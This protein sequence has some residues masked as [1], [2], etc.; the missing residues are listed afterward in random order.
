MH[1]SFPTAM[2]PWTLERSDA[3]VHILHIYKDYFPVVGG[4]ENHIRMLAEA[5]AAAGHRVTVL[6]CAP[7][8]RTREEQ[9]HGV[10]VIKAG[11]LGTVASMP[12]SISQP[13]YL[14]RLWPDIAHV[15][16]PYPLGEA[17]NWLLGRARA[18]VITY[19]SDIVRQKRLLWLYGPILHR[20]LR[21]ADAIIASSR[22]YLETSPWLGPLRERCTV[23]PL[24]IDLAR[25]TVPN[26]ASQNMPPTLLFVGKLRY[27]KGLDTLL[28]AMPM[29]DEARLVVVGDGPMRQAW[30]RLTAALKLGSRVEFVGEV[31]DADLL[32]YYTDADLFVLPANVRAEAFGT[33]L[34]E[35]M[36]MGLPVVSTELG[37][38]TS[39]V[40]QDGVT[41]RVVPAN[42]PQ[43]LAGAIQAL[44]TDTAC[45]Q[46]MAAAARER[47][48]TEF[49]MTVMVQRVE[50]V[51][52]KVLN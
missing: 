12:L 35:A 2:A 11:R 49:S 9:L 3:T 30:E 20:V 10:Q 52:E 4:I 28:G 34:L 29:I 19:Q 43:A 25:F 6:V 7:G 42:D 37:T 44:L 32:G 39:W 22:R 13:W 51:Y 23:V 8:Y 36:A 26:R 18:T 15:H 48:E 24:G 27:Y 40:N 38:G 31:P 50:A 16:V 47:V 17:A 33:V 14:T 45:R 1:V 41:G 46:R 5:Q 21:S